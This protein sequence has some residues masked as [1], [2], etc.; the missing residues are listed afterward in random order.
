VSAS[1]RKYHPFVVPQEHG[2][3]FDTTWFELTD[4]AGRGI[5]VQGSEPLTFSARRYSDAVL[6]SATTLAELEEH[7]SIEVHVDM[8]MRGLGTAAC[9]P[10]T[11]PQHVVGPGT[12]T[13]DW[14]IT[15]IG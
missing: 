9:G 12:Y 4:D 15:P 10:D 8:A 6:T 14:T 1:R 11:T 7:H 3:H 13:L 5:R 2:A